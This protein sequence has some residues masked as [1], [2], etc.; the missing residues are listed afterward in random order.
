[1]AQL[2]SIKKIAKIR[3]S[4]PRGSLSGQEKRWDERFQAWAEKP[5]GNNSHRTISK[6]SRECWFLI[7][8][9]KYL[10]SLIASKHFP[11]SLVV[12]LFLVSKVENESFPCMPNVGEQT[13]H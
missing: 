4:G 3:I 13:G 2:C 5:L 7:G 11:K 10:V 8:Y 12:L 9:K 1:M 6:Q